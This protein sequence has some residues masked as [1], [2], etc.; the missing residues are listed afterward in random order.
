MGYENCK[1]VDYGYFGNLEVFS[2]AA[3]STLMAHAEDCHTSI[4]WKLGVK[5]VE[6]FDLTMDGACPGN[7]PKGQENNRKWVP[8]CKGTATP[9]IHPFKKPAAYKKCYEETTR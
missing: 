4:D 1:Y 2:K 7:R 6:N 8:P 5:K 3:W 9:A